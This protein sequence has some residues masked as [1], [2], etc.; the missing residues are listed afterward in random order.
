MQRG[1]RPPAQ[2]PTDAGQRPPAVRRTLTAPP[3]SPA[4]EHPPTHSTM[5]PTA[6]LSGE[7]WGEQAQVP[8][9]RTI[10]RPTTGARTIQRSSPDRT[11]P[12]PSR[13]PSPRTQ[14]PSAA[15]TAPPSSSYRSPRTAPPAPKQNDAELEAMGQQILE[16]TE[17]LR[18]GDERSAYL[19]QQLNH[20]TH[21]AN[22][23]AA[24][25]TAAPPVLPVSE[26]FG[27][28]RAANNS[29]IPWT[30]FGLLGALMAAAY[31]FGYSPMR[32]SFEEQVKQNALQAS[33]SAQALTSLRS[34]FNEER[35]RFESQLAAAQAAATAATAAPAEPAAAP[36]RSRSSS[37]ASDEDEDDSSS[38]SRMTP[39]EREAKKAERK[40]A[41]EAKKAER[42]AKREEKRAAALERKAAREESSASKK[43]ASSSDDDEGATMPAS[44]AKPASKPSSSDDGN[45]PLQGLDGL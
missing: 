15:R 44:R 8:A 13:L 38:H 42:L 7:A 5:R 20:M 32:A 14:P 1:T 27:R 3:R 26:D 18:A 39:E 28:P 23:A 2:P 12:M 41:Y 6:E 30:A 21:M 9:S 40:A 22:A 11:Q 33:Q 43:H 31:V 29:W 10:P 16:L 36:T 24:A 4:S 45:D 17:R 19:E 25:A 34:T 35:Q 37:A